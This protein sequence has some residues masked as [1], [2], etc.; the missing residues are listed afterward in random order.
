MVF[1]SWTEL[2]LINKLDKIIFN[3]LTSF[4]QESLAQW[5]LS[6]C[7][8]SSSWN[9]AAQLPPLGQ[10]KALPIS[11]TNIQSNNMNNDHPCRITIF[12]TKIHDGIQ[13]RLIRPIAYTIIQTTDGTLILAINDM[14]IT[15]L[16]QQ[17]NRYI[18]PETRLNKRRGYLYYIIVHSVHVPRDANLRCTE[19]DLAE[20]KTRVGSYC[21]HILLVWTGPHSDMSVKIDNQFGNNMINKYAWVYHGTYV[22]WYQNCTVQINSIHL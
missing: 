13:Q 1:E 8:Q 19:C 7:N 18:Y 12:H 11:S 17:I 9:C 16:L 6:W 5:S 14:W 15:M 10:V 20:W 22:Y 4:L 2:T 21:E 3:Q